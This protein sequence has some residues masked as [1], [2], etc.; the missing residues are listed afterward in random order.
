MGLLHGSMRLGILGGCISWT[1]SVFPPGISYSKVVAALLFE[2]AGGGLSG[3]GRREADRGII[4][5]EENPPLGHIITLDVAD[6][7]RR[8]GVGT[9]LLREMEQHFG[10]QGWS[11]CCWKRP[12]RMRAGLRFGRGMDIVRRPW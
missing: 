9:M 2:F 5:A 8:R 10:F 11:R 7:F 4:L 3:G 6:G 1:R 12:W